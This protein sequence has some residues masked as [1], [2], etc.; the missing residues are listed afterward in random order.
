MAA[1]RQKAKEGETE[2]TST[3]CCQMDAVVTIDGRGQIVL[4]KDIRQRLGL[5][6]GDKLA[7]VSYSRDAEACC[8]I[9]MKTGGFNGMVKVVLA[10]MAKEVLGD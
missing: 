1:K 2:E 7:V 3:S 8:I 5:K 10:P 6:A 4:P 9:L